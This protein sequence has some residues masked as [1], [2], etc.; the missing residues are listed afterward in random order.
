MDFRELLLQAR[1][2]PSKAAR[3]LNLS[4]RTIKRYLVAGTAPRSVELALQFHAGTHPNWHGWRIN[5]DLIERPGLAPLHRN[6]LEQFE[7]A[8]DL[9]Y[10]RGQAQGLQDAAGSRAKLADLPPSLYPCRAPQFPQHPPR[11]R[12]RCRAQRSAPAL[13]NLQTQQAAITAR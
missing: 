7:Y 5:G 10:K 13:R 1:L 8:M 2:S 4:V 12:P 6:Q 3:Y 9:A 11:I